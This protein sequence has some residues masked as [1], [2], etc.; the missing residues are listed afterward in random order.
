VEVCP[1]R[2]NIVLSAVLTASG[3]VAPR[4]AADPV[5]VQSGFVVTNEDPTQSFGLDF[6]LVGEGF[7][8]VGEDTDSFEYLAGF[9][10]SAPPFHL[11]FSGVPDPS[12]NSSCP[13]CLY[14][15]EFQFLFRPLDSPGSE[16]F[17]MSAV[18]MGTLPGAGSPAI[19]AEVAGRGTMQVGG[20]SLRFFFEAD[21]AP[22]PEPSTLFL[23][24]TGLQRRGL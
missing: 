10:P 7:S 23:V 24:A 18:L 16:A 15:D 22:V 13:G 21:P 2:W 14:A 8:F 11:R 19:T 17:T 9:S 1:V 4:A 3:F 5:R 20:S 12:S 6:G